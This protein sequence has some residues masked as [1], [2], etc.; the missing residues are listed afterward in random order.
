MDGS[1]K[2]AVL[3]GWDGRFGAAN[4]L[5]RT[6]LKSKNEQ[7]IRICRAYSMEF[8]RAA[9]RHYDTYKNLTSSFILKFYD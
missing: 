9:I 4:R 6:M 1:T 7:D 2:S 8:K 5:G 3:T